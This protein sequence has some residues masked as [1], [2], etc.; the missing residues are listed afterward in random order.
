[1]GSEPLRG[2]AGA[3]A[4]GGGA[5]AAVS[6]ASAALAMNGCSTGAGAPGAAG[7][8]TSSPCFQFVLLCRRRRQTKKASNRARRAPTPP[9]TPPATAPT[10]SVLGL[11][12]G[13]GD[14]D[15]VEEVKG[16]DDDNDDGENAA[17]VDGG[18]VD[19]PMPKG[20][21][22]GVGEGVEAALAQWV[23]F[24]PDSAAKSVCIVSRK[25]V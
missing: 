24:W 9:A 19:A 14:G 16:E 23:R 15:E 5:Y 6:S 3:S 12:E 18:V 2:A 1:M 22:V 20:F 7:A 21:G 25:N 11:G 10:L 8:I 17:N 4:Y 13:V